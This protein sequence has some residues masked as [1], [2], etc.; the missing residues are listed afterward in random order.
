MRRIFKT[1][2]ALITMASMMLCGCGGKG[3]EFAAQPDTTDDNYRVFYQV[4]VG[5]FSDS[6][7]DGIGDIRGIISKLDYLKDLG[8]NA[9]WLR[10]FTKHLMM[11]MVTISPIIGI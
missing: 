5:S 1:G 4:F 9:V 10:L 8:V 11:I 7:G 6:N 2:L 3:K